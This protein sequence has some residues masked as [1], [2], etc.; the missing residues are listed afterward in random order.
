MP[1]VAPWSSSLSVLVALL[2]APAATAQYVFVGPASD[3]DCDYTT[4]QAA[5]AMG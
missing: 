5:V 4:I 2:A 3:P 1:H